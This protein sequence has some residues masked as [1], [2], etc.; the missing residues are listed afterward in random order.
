[1]RDADKLPYLT[2]RFRVFLHRLE[3]TRARVAGRAGGAAVPADE[4]T[5]DAPSVRDAAAALVEA[6]GAAARGEGFDAGDPDLALALWLMARCG[7]AAFA[8]L[9]GW[10]GASAPALT[11]VWPPPVELSPDLGE[12]VAVLLEEE[13]P[14]PHR[15]ELYLL[16]LA[17]EAGEADGDDSRVPRLAAAA[18]V[19][20]SGPP[21]TP[22]AP[23]FPAA[24]PPP[25]RHGPPRE[26]PPVA[27]WVTA[28]LAVAAGLLLASWL[29]WAWA[30]GDLE[31][32]LHQILGSGG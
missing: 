7:D 21:A 27:G 24:Y 25:R 3:R 15:A 23:L 18:A 10:G 32:L 28:C 2:R 9:P 1:M 11:T 20:R 13:V 4:L 31:R 8:G 19:G 16:A 12:Q 6:E 17:G 14:D 29:I 26:V 5:G 30:A 22:D